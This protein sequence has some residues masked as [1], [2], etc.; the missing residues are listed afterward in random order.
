MNWEIGIHIYTLPYVKQSSSGNLLYSAG[1]SGR[2][3]VMTSTGRSEGGDTC[4]HTADSLLC[5]AETN[6]TL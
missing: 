2:A 1:S 4:I 3:S 5:I 6:A